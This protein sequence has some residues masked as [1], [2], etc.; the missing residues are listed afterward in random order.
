M[1]NRIEQ[2][3]VLAALAGVLCLGAAAQRTTREIPSTV[4]A[5]KQTDERQPLKP[6]LPGLQRAHRLILKDGSYQLVREYQILGE[7]VR[8]F[9]QE[10]ADWEEMPADLVDWNATRKWENAHNPAADD[11][12]ELSPVMKEARELDK[13][14]QE[15][16][17]DQNGR[18]PEVAPGLD[19]PDEDGV[20]ALDTYQGGPELVEI[21]ASDMNLTARNKKGLGTLNPL[22]GQTA[23]LEIEGAHARI[24]LHVNDPVLYISLAT[25]SGNATA[26]PGAMTINTGGSKAVNF[27]HG[28]RSEKS[29]FA[30]VRVSQR[31]AV[32]MVGAVHV[33]R[34]GTV[35]Q[36]EDVIAATVEVLP[37]K[38]WL[39]IHPEQPLAIGEYAL[40]EIL[41]PDDINPTVWD[42]RVDPT[43]GSNPGS[44]TP[45]LKPAG[46]RR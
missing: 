37:G 18:S 44:L 9:S 4:P 40:V 15:A 1:A 17:N 11:S 45:I 3:I 2:R 31:N 38:H 34:D 33:A 23:S 6:D 19:L 8:Y 10:R 16:R 41:S 35:T 29:G 30:I 22:A 42:F 20:F 21:P 5:Q 7:R 46:S 13:A 39:K 36:D 25:D 12:E 32:R 26:A 43:K 14:E 24:H 28:A 27:K